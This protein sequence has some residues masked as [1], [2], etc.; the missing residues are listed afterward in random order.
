MTWK[1]ISVKISTLPKLPIY[2]LLS[3]KSPNYTVLYMVKSISQTKLDHSSN[4]FT[5]T[6]ETQIKFSERCIIISW[7]VFRITFEDWTFVKSFN[8]QLV[9]FLVRIS[10]IF[11]S[12]HYEANLVCFQGFIPNGEVHLSHLH[13]GTKPCQFTTSQCWAL[14]WVTLSW[15]HKVYNYSTLSYLWGLETN[16]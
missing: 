13:T 8:K 2:K 12:S 5:K 4:K 6:Y 1:L 7:E 10:C 11:Y 14:L 9:E 3:Y 15:Q 16:W